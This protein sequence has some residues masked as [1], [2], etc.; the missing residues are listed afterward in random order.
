M[1]VQLQK[2][3]A[4]AAVNLTPLIDCV[5]LLLIFFLVASRI[6]DEEP[7]LDLELPNVSE[8]LPAVFEP[9]ELVVNVDGE[10]RFFVD[11]SF[12]PA[13]QV[14]QLLR[15]AYETNPLTQSVVIRGDRR[16]AWEHI[17]TVISLCK[18]VG[19]QQYAATMED[20]Q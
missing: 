3:R 12:R 15:V 2:N 6:A 1:A 20:N 5:F 17:A 19:I 14:E 10:G 4:A 16:C 13:E 8:A 11:G 7:Q 9:Q 18:K